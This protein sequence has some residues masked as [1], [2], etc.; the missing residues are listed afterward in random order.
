MAKKSTKSLSDEGDDTLSQ[1]F[2][3]TRE[4]WNDGIENVSAS[5]EELSAQ[6][7]QFT[8]ELYDSP[9]GKRAQQH[10]VAAIGIASLVLFVCRKLL[11]R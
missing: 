4:I 9:L 1:D 2:Q 7:S 3:A 6:L 8:K 5:V 11:R 10:P